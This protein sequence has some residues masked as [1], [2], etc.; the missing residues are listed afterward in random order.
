MPSIGK[1]KRLNRLF[2]SS[3]TVIIVPMDHGI[4]VGP[5]K[6]LDDMHST[7]GRLINGG[8]D[9]I[10]LNKG[11]I[12]HNFD[13]LKEKAV[14]VIMHLSG[15]TDMGINSLYKVPTGTIYEAL[16]MGCDAVSVHINLGSDKEPD[17]LRD[18]AAISSECYQYGLPLLAMIY[19]RGGKIR[20]EYDAGLIK[21]AARLGAEIGA[22]IV[23]VNYT[24]DRNSFEEVVRSCP[25][26]VII[27]GGEKINDDYKLLRMVFEAIQ[28]GAKGVSIGRNIFQHN[29]IEALLKAISFIVHQNT[30]FETALD[31]Y[32]E[33][34]RP[35]PLQRKTFISAN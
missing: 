29:N 2:N 6:G 18:L 1:I 15:S 23:K 31:A 5:I 20:N 33:S 11:M 34:T 30:S 22:D 12:P 35:H 16:A 10:L 25:V 27:A 21:H 17:M 32:K 26:P 3:G 13:S 4:T 7:I 8:A 14:G 19:T 9:A 24:G 28:A